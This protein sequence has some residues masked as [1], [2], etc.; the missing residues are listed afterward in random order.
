MRK[1]NMKKNIF[2]LIASVSLLLAMSCGEDYLK[3]DHYDILPAT[4]MFENEANINAGLNGIYDT[5]YPDKEGSG[6]AGVWGFKPQMFIASHPTLDCQAGGWDNELC[7]HEWRADKDMFKFAW[8]ASYFAISRINRF[9]DGLQEVDPSMFTGGQNTKNIIE[10]E[11][12][13]IR[14]YNYFFLAKTFG[15]VPMLQTGETYSNTPSKPRPDNLQETYDLII[16]DFVYAGNTLDWRPFNS[17]YG[18]I[19]KGMC[20]SYLAQVYMY[21]KDFQKAKGLIEEVINSGV[22]TLNPCYGKIFNYES[23]WTSESIW[24]VMYPMHADMGWGATGKTDA[25]MWYGYMCASP[26]Y[27]GWGSLYVSHEYVNSFETGDKRKQYSVV[28]KGDTNP[29]TGE[30]TGVK[31]G[32]TDDLVGSEMMPNNYSL[33]Y[34]RHRPGTGNIVYDPISLQL[35]RYAEILLDYAE[36]C[37]ETGDVAKG[38]EYIA[39]IRDRAW[40]NLEVSLPENDFVL[41]LNRSEVS[42]PD[43]QTYYAKYKTDKGYSADVWQVALAIERRHEFNAEFSLYQD[44]CRTGMIKEFLDNEYPV[45]KTLTNRKFTFDPNHM[46][47]PIPAQEIL[48]NAAITQADQNPGY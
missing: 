16:E 45:G 24:E 31:I 41:P 28:A 39:K 8:Q 14:A 20:K 15:P 13:G 2:N 48:T 7:R 4:F 10:A 38:W 46:I 3:I 1:R 6:D 32:F 17:Q 21:Q 12:R 9:L 44:L 34:W 26:E 27:S 25:V 47:F 43:A 36:C 19:T 42:V 35:L 11:A 40:G 18:R 22:Y 33:K 37:F 5:F 23:A 29:F 30:T